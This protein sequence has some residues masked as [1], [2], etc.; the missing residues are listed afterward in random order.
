MKNYEFLNR[1]AVKMEIFG[2]LFEKTTNPDDFTKDFIIMKMIMKV[3]ETYYPY[4]MYDW[5]G[6]DEIF[7]GGVCKRN[8]FIYCY[9]FLLI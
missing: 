9:N 8:T 1:M 3:G 4:N 6:D 7:E 5:D 2:V